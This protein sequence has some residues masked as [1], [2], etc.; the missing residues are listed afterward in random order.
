MLQ[1]EY[2]SPDVFR[3]LLLPDNFNN[4]VYSVIDD[5]PPST[6]GLFV[7]DLEKDGLPNNIPAVKQNNSVTVK[8][9]GK[10]LLIYY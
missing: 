4:S 8:G 5:I 3:A 2:G 9:E 7:Y 10:Y 6:Y 1:C